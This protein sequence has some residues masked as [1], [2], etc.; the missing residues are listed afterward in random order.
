MSFEEWIKELNDHGVLSSR[1]KFC[2]KRTSLFDAMPACW[3]KLS[4][5]Q[6][7]DAL[8]IIKQVHQAAELC[9]DKPNWPKTAVIAL[10]RF[11]KLED[12]CKF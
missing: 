3:T 6:Q 9:G 7:H 2:T 10:A 1:E 4:V 8:S 11:A 12:V 5:E